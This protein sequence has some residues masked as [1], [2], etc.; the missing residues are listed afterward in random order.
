MVGRDGAAEP[1]VGCEA[2]EREHRVL[3]PRVFGVRLDPRERRLGSRTL[4]LELGDEDGVLAAGRLQVGDRPFVREEPEAG[5]VR[6]V[7]RVEERVPGGAE[8]VDTLEQPRAAVG[9]L[10]R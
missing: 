10:V 8:R 3:R 2:R 1:E 9:V 6:D 5:E 7:R 4:N